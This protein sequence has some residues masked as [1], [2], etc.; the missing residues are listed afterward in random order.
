MVQDRYRGRG[1]MTPKRTEF[2]R[3]IALGK[4]QK[5]A[6]LGAGYSAKSAKRLMEIPDIKAALEKVKKEIMDSTKYDA[7]AA[8][9]ELND[10][11]EFA[12]TTRNA[13]ALVRAVEM[14]MK[15]N[16]LIIDRSEQKQVGGF[17]IQILGIGNSAPSV[18]ALPAE[19]DIT[20]ECQ[21]IES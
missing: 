20:T 8:Q 19:K 10:A 21:K 7:L 14:K 13:T 17:Q 16:G 3:L 2:V 9:A 4:S 11:I 12:R 6:A 15:L 1:K 5:D 18:P